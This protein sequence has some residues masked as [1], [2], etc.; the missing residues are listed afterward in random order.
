MGL[1]LRRGRGGRIAEWDGK[2][3]GE[4]MKKRRGGREG[5]RKGREKRA[6]PQTPDQTPP[7]VVTT[8]FCLS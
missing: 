5:E 3:E 4:G 7:M 2:E 6:P 1:L 8:Y